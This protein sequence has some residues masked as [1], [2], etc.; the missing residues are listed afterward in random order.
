MTNQAVRLWTNVLQGFSD[1]ASGTL[2]SMLGVGDVLE[3]LVALPEQ[4]KA[5]WKKLLQ[6][7]QVC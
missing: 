3:Q 7:L 4:P 1:M 2:Q 6:E 5:T